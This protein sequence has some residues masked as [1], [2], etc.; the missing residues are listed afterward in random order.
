MCKSDSTEPPAPTES[1]EWEDFAPDGEWGKKKE[2][3]NQMY[4]MSELHFPGNSGHVIF[5][6]WVHVIDLGL[7]RSNNWC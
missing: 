5:H 6:F 7:W 3:E 2:G 1:D 4:V